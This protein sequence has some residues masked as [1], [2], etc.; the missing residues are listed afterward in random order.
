VS[1]AVLVMAKAPVAG[2][3]KTRLGAVVG[4]AAAADLA[5]A[6][7]LD[8]LDVCQSVFTGRE[9]L[10]VA[11]AGALGS[12]RPH[13]EI[14]DR[15]TRWTVHPQRGASFASRLVNAHLDVG[16]AAGASVVQIGMDTP[17]LTE[18]ALRD[19]AERLGGADDAVLGPAED[20]GWW[21][22]GLTR[23]E[24]ARG[25]GGVRMSTPRTCA[26][27]LTALRAGGARV[28]L[29][30]TLRDVDTVQDAT[31]VAQE[32]PHTRFG[33]LWTRVVSARGDT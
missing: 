15:L 24:L 26:D 12:T 9:R 10:H 5:A 11:L 6:C 1:P 28:G 3:A 14:A 4:A 21:V 19:V 27:T 2:Q 17:H 8:T 25:L 29:A 32:A 18:E 7:I 16:H 31:A 33:R 22:L 30:A 20:G 23:P 13:Q